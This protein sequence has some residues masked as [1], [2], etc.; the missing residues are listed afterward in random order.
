LPTPV[1]RSFRLITGNAYIMLLTAML[2]WAMNTVAARLAVGEIS[3]MLLVLLRWI[4]ACGILLVI[5]RDALKADWPL[6][7]TRLPYVFFMGALGYTAFNALFYAAGHHTTAI[8]MGI[9]QGSM[10]I[11]VMVTGVMV[12]REHANIWQWVGTGFTLLGIA[13]V[14]SGGDLS[15]LKDFTFNIGDIWMLIACLLY[16]G[17]T[18]ALRKRPAASGLGFFAVMAAAAAVTSVP[19]AAGEFMNGAVLWPGWKGWLLVLFIGLGPSLLAQ[20]TF[21]RGV[22]LIGPMRSGVFINLVPVIGPIFA[23][24]ILGE[25]FSWHHGLALLLVLGGIWIAEWGR[26]R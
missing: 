26:K 9:M 21:M 22:E 25:K 20:L 7:K 14:A 6:L 12:L 24:L 4:L 11:L 16:A 3:P 8:N 15:R 2:L 18:V 19:L 10:P 23:I 13:L 1:A 5:A 17:Y